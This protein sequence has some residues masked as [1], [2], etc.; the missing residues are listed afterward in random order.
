MLREHRFAAW[1]ALA[2]FIVLELLLAG[3]ILFWPSFKENIAPLRALVPIKELRDQ[4]DQMAQTGIAGYVNGQHFF[5]GCNTLGTLA[6]VIFAMGAVAGEAYRGTLEL[7]LS[8]PLSRRRI[9]LERFVAGALAV[10]L[11]VFATSATVPLLLHFVDERMSFGALMLSSAHESLLLLAIY[12][13]TFLYS[14]LS[15]KLLQIG[16]T[17]LLFTVFQFG[18]YMIKHLTHASIFRLTDITVFAR[19]DATHALDMSMVLPLSA[20]TVVALVLSLVAFE[21]RVP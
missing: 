20:V 18:M 5:K 10:V 4:F 21:R 17:M 14:T 8:R 15:S 13:L 9:L 2:W 11:P 16:F 1:G 3:A 7:W 12:S 19:I 6:A